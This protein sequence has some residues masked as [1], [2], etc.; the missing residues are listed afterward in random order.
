MVR[1]T[2]L[3][4]TDEEVIGVIL[5][6]DAH[7]G[8]TGPGAPTEPAVQGEESD[9]ASLRTPTSETSSDDS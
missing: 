7:D 6:M 5:L 1:V 2:P 4:G 9:D 3:V 8:V